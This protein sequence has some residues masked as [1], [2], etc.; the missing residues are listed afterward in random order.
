MAV[1]FAVWTLRATLLYAVDESIASPTLRAT[2]SDLLK[3]LLWVLPAVA[4]V[5]WV[6]GL[7]PGE[8]WVLGRGPGPGQWKRCLVVTAV[9]LVVSAAFELGTGHKS[10]SL[11]V[12]RGTPPVI[13]VLFYL[14]SPLLEELL[15]RSFV[16]KEL[17]GLMPLAAANVVA[18]LLFVGAHLPYWLSHGGLTPAVAANCF[19]IFLFSLLAGWV[20]AQSGSVWPAGVAH[21][22][23]N[24]L[25]AV[26]VAGKA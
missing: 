5:R 15:F 13:G 17:L 10:F 6:K 8:Y 9:F 25:A 3:F 7:A 26:V 18:S 24:L 23:N 22:A 1:F 16:L 14:V 20:F 4:W 19:G 21:I 12:L 2:Y 11:A